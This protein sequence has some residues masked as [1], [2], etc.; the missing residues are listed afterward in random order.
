MDPK[1]ISKLLR[2]DMKSIEVSSR[3]I[4][5]PPLIHKISEK[6]FAELEEIVHRIKAFYGNLP[7]AIAEKPASAS[8]LNIPS[9]DSH[10][11]KMPKTRNQQDIHNRPGNKKE[12]KGHRS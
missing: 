6:T 4:S 10:L 2:E 1:L 9:W 11:I 3:R 7:R 5:T 8:T 12:N